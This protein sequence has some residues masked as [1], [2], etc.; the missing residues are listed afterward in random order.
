MFRSCPIHPCVCWFALALICCSRLL[1]TSK[2][3]VSHERLC[4]EVVVRFDLDLT[5]VNL[6]QKCCGSKTWVNSFSWFLFIVCW[7]LQFLADSKQKFSSTSIVLQAWWHIESPEGF[8]VLSLSLY[9]CRRLGTVSDN[10]SDALSAQTREA[11]SWCV[12]E[13]GRSSVPAVGAH[14]EED[15]QKLATF[16]LPW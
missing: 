4:S 6:D 11:H 3:V 2:L 7:L 1:P 14:T 16:W 10:F 12:R 5:E 9:L 13:L 15:N 8:L